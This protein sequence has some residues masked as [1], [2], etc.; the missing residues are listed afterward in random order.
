MDGWTEEFTVRIY[1]ST[2]RN[3]VR[4]KGDGSIGVDRPI[5]CNKACT[6]AVKKVVVCILLRGSH[7][8]K[9]GGCGSISRNRHVPRI[10]TMTCFYHSLA[11]SATTPFF[12]ISKRGLI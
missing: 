8:T 11:F 2:V 4:R 3:R 7:S 6:C 12:A 10:M 1:P 5:D 9:G